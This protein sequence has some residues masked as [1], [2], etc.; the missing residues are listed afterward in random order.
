MPHPVTPH[1]EADLAI[2][3]HVLDSINAGFQ[4]IVGVTDTDITLILLYHIP[5]FLQ[6]GQKELWI[7]ADKGR[8]LNIC[9]CIFFT[10]GWVEIY[11][12]FF[13]LCIH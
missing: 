7:G 13:Q 3:P 8:Q 10:V 1:T 12:L 5:R 9:R 4:K 11:A 2:P 6:Y